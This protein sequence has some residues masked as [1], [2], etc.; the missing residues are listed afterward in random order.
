MRHNEMMDGWGIG[1][2]E[3]VAPSR[4]TVRQNEVDLAK[5]GCYAPWRR[6]R[7]RIFDGL[8]PSATRMPS[9]AVR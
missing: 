7:V 6:T 8:A 5:S 4:E 9:S 3:I 1:K 2:F